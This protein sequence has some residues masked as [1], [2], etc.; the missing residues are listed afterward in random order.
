MTSLI[1]ITIICFVKGNTIQVDL[2]TMDLPCLDVLEALVADL[3]PAP[4]KPASVITQR[5]LKFLLS[6]FA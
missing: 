3:S 1:G 6:R 4:V 5:Y 2:S